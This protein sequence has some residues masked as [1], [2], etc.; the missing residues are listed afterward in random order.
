[1]GAQA[2][3]LVPG[4]DD[5]PGQGPHPGGDGLGGDGLGVD[6]GGD[7]A[8]APG[9]ILTW[10]PVVIAAYSVLGLWSANVF[11]VPTRDATAI[12]WPVIGAAVAAWVVALVAMWA[13]RRPN[14]IARGGLVAS[15]GGGTFLLAGRILPGLDPV[16]GLAAVA[17]VAVGAIWLGLSIRGAALAALTTI[18]NVFALVAVGLAVFQLRP[19][20]SPTRATPVQVEIDGAGTAARDIWYIIPDRYPRLDTLADV[21]DFDNGE[22]EGFLEERGFTIQDRARANYPK[23]AH[24]LAATWN[25]EFLPDLVPQ[26]P[27]DG[28]DWRPLYELLAD[29]QLG[30]IVTEAGFDYVHLGSWW[31]PTQTAVS[32]TDVRNLGDTTEFETVWVPTTALRWFGGDDEEV[33]FDRRRHIHDV[34]SYQLDELDRLVDEDH[35]RPRLVLAHVTLPHE[36]YVFD[37]DGSYVDRETEQGRSRAENTVNQMRHLNSRLE[38][39]V[40]RL[41]TG[42]PERDPIIVIQSD[43]GPHPQVQYE[44]PVQWLEVST[45]ERAEKLRTFSAWYLPGVDEVPPADTTG[46]NTWRFI[47]DEYFGTVLGQLDN[48]VW[49]FPNEERLYEFEEVTDEFD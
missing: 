35:E 7:G 44:Q 25:M 6:G 14:P 13:A 37:V 40:D 15:I 43:E 3:D 2:P 41:V 36:P 32:A 22:F 10:H 46:V 34:T 1:M 11:E 17:A 30:R 24:S 47:I 20:L 31:T 38:D 27:E 4:H 19:V 23:T 39:L 29:H 48:R 16:T 9:R 21:Y 5:D 28:S 18:V 33:E 49:V 42:D 8:D 12:L 26:P 45:A